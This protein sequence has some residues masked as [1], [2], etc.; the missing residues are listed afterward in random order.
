MHVNYYFAADARKEYPSLGLF[1]K[2]Q[3]V[4]QSWVVEIYVKQWITK[5]QEVED[6]ATAM[7]VE[8]TQ[9]PDWN[10]VFMYCH[11]SLV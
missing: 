6:T 5:Q 10:T 7:I 3:R 4:N 1:Q 11:W 8:D 2:S 9:W